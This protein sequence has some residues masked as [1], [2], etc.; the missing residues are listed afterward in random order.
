MLQIKSLTIQGFR[1]FGDQPFILELS[2]LGP[3]LMTGSNGA[4]KSSI[5]DAILWCLFGTISNADR[6]A[7]NVINWNLKNCMVKLETL[8]GYVVERH[9]GTR[10]ELL[11]S[12]DGEDLTVSTN[13]NAQKRL[14]RI[15][16]LDLELFK[17]STFFGQS[18]RAFLE[19]SDMKRR[20]TMERFLHLHRVNMCGTV[21]TEKIKIYERDQLV[22]IRERDGIKH[23]LERDND[24]LEDLQERF[25]D[26]KITQNAQ[27]AALHDRIKQM[28]QD[29]RQLQK[30]ID[31][32]ELPDL[33]A[34]ARD[35]HNYNQIQEKIAKSR[36]QVQ[37][38]RH[39]QLREWQIELQSCQQLAAQWQARRGK[40][41]SKCLQPIKDQHIEHQVSQHA[42]RIK[43]LQH[44]IVQLEHA[45][46]Q[47]EQKMELVEKKVEKSRPSISIIE[48]EAHQRTFQQLQKRLAQRT[49]EINYLTEE[50]KKKQK[51]PNPHRQ[52]I[53]Q[54]QQ[55]IAE[56]QQ[57]L[58]EIEHKIT[59]MDLLLTHT[60]YLKS[61]YSDKNK[62]KSL[63]L[64]DLIPFLNERL[65]Y[66]LEAMG[67]D[68]V[69]QFTQALQLKSDK[70]NYEYFSGGERKRM[71]VAVMFALYDL[72]TAIYGHQCNI[73]VLDEI[74]GRLDTQGIEA[75]VDVIW[76]DFAKKDDAPDATI[77]IS[78]KKEMIDQFPTR[79]VVSKEDA[80]SS[81]SVES[82]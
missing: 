42:P 74:D 2:K 55:L 79:I 9:R 19:L 40:I 31:E 26:F 11:L 5:V 76:K 27:I 7:N 67:M 78:H 63:I 45:L 41:C 56:R 51:E 52:P 35:W 77:I 3:T 44:K 46:N 81:I 72:H 59:K 69:I 50:I 65:A 28:Q 53:Q 29:K 8:D 33:E 54:L 34:L 32:M 6:P 82:I 15:F 75:F 12:K 18:S 1:S 17:A 25:K 61:M 66:Y 20:R 58:Q 30:E 39:N 47:K 48:A 62:L 24:R 36:K 73:V 4:G 80:F 64:T 49:E 38:M 57:Q 16:N 22:L 60:A 10:N 23:D 21:A 14:E 37:N 13:I 68:T 71:D 43:Q 70:W